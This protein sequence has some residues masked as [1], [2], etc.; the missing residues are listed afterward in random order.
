MCEI[1]KSFVEEG[2]VIGA[3]RILRKHGSSDDEIKKEMKEEF[4]L[5]DYEAESFIKG[6]GGGVM[7]G[8]YQSDIEMLGEGYDPPFSFMMPLCQG[9]R[10]S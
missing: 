2:E 7:D 4:G 1:T 3:V 8:T 10:R 9:R 5:T 6:A